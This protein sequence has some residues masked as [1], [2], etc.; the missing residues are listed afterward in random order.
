MKDP[1]AAAFAHISVTPLDKRMSKGH[2]DGKGSGQ[3][4]TTLPKD[5]PR[6]YLFKFATPLKTEARTQV[7]M[8]TSLRAGVP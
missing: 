8:R 1:S 2:Q 5:F 4:L 3:V 7:E 6:F